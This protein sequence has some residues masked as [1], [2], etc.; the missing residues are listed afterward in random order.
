MSVSV[1]NHSLDTVQADASGSYNFL[2]D[3]TQ[4]DEGYYFVNAYVNPSS[5]VSYVLS[6]DAPLRPQEG[7]GTIFDVPSGIAY[8]N[9]IYLPNVQK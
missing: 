5:T 8:T 6:S 1:N 3:T 9:T 7:S 4:S 2:L